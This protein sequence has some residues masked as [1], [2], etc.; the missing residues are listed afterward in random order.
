MIDVPWGPRQALLGIVGL[1]AVAGLA[2]GIAIL[3]SQM[4]DGPGT[5]AWVVLA[6]TTVLQVGMGGIA[7]ALGPR[8]RGSSV[9]LLGPRRLATATLFGWG[10]I[11]FLGLLAA[12]VVYVQT[13]GRLSDDLLPPPLPAELSIDDVRLAAF[14]SIV[15]VAPMIE[16]TF[17][18]GFLFAGLLRRFGLWTAVGVSSAVFAASHL[19][20]ALLGPAFL[21]GAVLALAYWR[22]RSIWPGILAHTAQN[23]IAF[24]LVV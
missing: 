17:F 23:A 21:G 14:V 9:M 16:E 13:V 22:T 11:A 20:V 12:N 18:R 15:I 8:G 24:G 3:L 10:V 4:S 5:P 19:D 7:Y 1:A 6:A 2:T